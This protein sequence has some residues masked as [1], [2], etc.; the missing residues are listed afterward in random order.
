MLAH[1]LA[2][3][4]AAFLLAMVPGPGT[5]LILRQTVRHG[6][7][8][9]FATLAGM[10]G[11]IAFWAL[12]TVLGLSALVAASQVA[13]DVIR[14]CG[15]VVLVVLGLQSLRGS[16]RSAPPHA[17][18]AALAVADRRAF[19]AGLVTNI[20]N[21]KAAVFAVSF[22]PQFVPAGAPVAATLALLAV[23]QVVCD[24]T[25]YVVV[26]LA[27]HRARAVFTRPSVRRRMEQA[28][29]VALVGFGVAVAA[30]TR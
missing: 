18:A 21:P 10:E 15:A 24:T 27:L 2:F 28:S 14:I 12:A 25:W 7:R 4:G 5:A 3:A 17:D 20:A 19:R 6:R 26:I 22:L 9:G 1:V 30:E 13:Y 8:Q 29:G 16:R 23:V 11:G